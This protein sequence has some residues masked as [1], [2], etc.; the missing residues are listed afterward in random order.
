MFSSSLQARICYFLLLTENS[1]SNTPANPK[2][3]SESLGVGLKD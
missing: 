3:E 2:F 1:F